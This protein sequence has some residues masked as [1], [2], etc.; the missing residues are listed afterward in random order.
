MHGV[1]GSHPSI[2]IFQYGLDMIGVFLYIVIRRSPMLQ[3]PNLITAI[4]E[5]RH[6]DVHRAVRP[7]QQSCPTR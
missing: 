4:A 7:T 2:G 5:A 3:S 1:H 6:Q